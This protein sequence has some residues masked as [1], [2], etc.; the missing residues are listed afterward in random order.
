M[1]E[2]ELRD[3]MIELAESYQYGYDDPYVPLV[4]AD[5]CEWREFVSARKKEFPARVRTEPNSFFRGA[6]DRYHG[7][8]SPPQIEVLVLSRV[9]FYADARCLQEMYFETT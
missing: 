1:S 6:F 9:A 8:I 7:R 5:E 4:D 2:I 3:R